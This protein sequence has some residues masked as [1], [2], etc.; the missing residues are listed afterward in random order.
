V[1]STGPSISFLHID[2][3]RSKNM[4]HRLV[5]LSSLV[6]FALLLCASGATAEG[7]A[8][9]APASPQAALGTAFTYQGRLDQ[10]GSPAS[11]TY[12]FRFRLYDDG[13]A[14]EGTQLGE[15]A[16]GDVSVSSGL[17]SVE[18]DFGSAFDTGTATWLEIGVR[19]GTSTGSYTTLNPRQAVNAVP[20]ALYARSISGSPYENIVVV[21][22]SGGDTTT[23]QGAIDS[24]TDANEDNPYLVWVAPGEYLESVTMKP[25][26]HLQGAGQ[27]TTVISSTVTNDWADNPLLDATLELSS[28]VTVRDLK[29]INSGA[30]EVNVALFA[31]E[32]IQ[33]VEV[34]DVVVEAL[35][36][37]TI[38]NLALYANGSIITLYSID[39]LA[40]NGTG[41][42]IGLYTA[43]GA[44]V[45]LVDCDLSGMGGDQSYGISN[46]GA[47]SSLIAM[48]SNAYGMNSDISTG[49]HNSESA[50]AKLEGGMFKG[51]GPGNTAKGIFNEKDATLNAKNIYAE[52][53]LG[54]EN[55][56]IRISDAYGEISHS[57]IYGDHWSLHTM[58]LDAELY[59]SFSTLQEQPG[60]YEGL[61][62]CTAM[63]YDNAFYEDTCP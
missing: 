16:V 1:G 22:K 59:A 27:A 8:P 19:A 32:G 6:V 53:R 11:G 57:V 31:P 40:R 51:T 15:V 20:Y 42:N 41:V 9:N 30:G 44:I 56:G 48:N 49:L 5:I 28:H 37:S 13:Y 60:L 35:G 33:H 2:L 39:A 17:F 25:Y 52:G 38:A 55:E 36:S 62:T 12:D 46:T 14:G 47:G 50:S 23:V 29:I 26:V 4:N 43:S 63:M 21:A 18:L 3:E 34:S 54:S 7:S 45:E 24:I 58:G 10:S 61:Y